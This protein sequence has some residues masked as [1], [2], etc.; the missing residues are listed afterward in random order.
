MLFKRKLIISYLLGIIVMRGFFAFGVEIG[1]PNPNAKIG[2]NFILNILGEPNTLHPITSTDLFARYVHY[3]TVDTLADYNFTNYEMEP[4]LAEKWEI[5]KDGKEY[6]FNL[7]KNIKFHDGKPVTA[8]DIKFSFD[9]IFGSKNMKPHTFAPITK[10][11]KKW[12]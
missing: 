5:S 2:G 9:I 4:H 12:K 8:E 10:I 6:T 1:A 11:F 7:R 3:L